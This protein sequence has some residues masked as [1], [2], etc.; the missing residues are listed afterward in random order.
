M[1]NNYRYLNAVAEEFNIPNN[2]IQE[3]RSLDGILTYLIHLND[4]SKFQYDIKEIVGSKKALEKIHK[5]YKNNGLEE[6]NK[7]IDLLDFIDKQQ[8]LT[9]TKF[10]R[11][12]CHR[13]YN[14]TNCII[15]RIKFIFLYKRRCCF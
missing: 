7:I 3:V 11:Y 14:K 4:K 5:A 8:H 12:A 2:Y 6:E 10:I 1:F 9:F 15:K 13:W